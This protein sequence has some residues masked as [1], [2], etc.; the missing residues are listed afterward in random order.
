MNTQPA[1]MNWRKLLGCVVAGLALAGAAHAQV[2]SSVPPAAAG[3][4]VVT[5]AVRTPPAPPA[6]P[7]PPAPQPPAVPSPDTFI[8][9]TTGT[10]T[11]TTV[12]VVMEDGTVVGVP[13]TSAPTN[14]PALPAG[15]TP[16]PGE[17]VVPS[18]EPSGDPAAPPPTTA[19]AADTD[20]TNAPPAVLVP[21]PGRLTAPPAT[22]GGVVMPPSR[23]PGVPAAATTNGVPAPA[24]T[25]QWA[26][27]G[28]TLMSTN[29]LISL[30]FQDAPVD[31]ILDF[32]A[33]MTGRTL[34]RAPD[35]AKAA[36][37]TLRGQTRL[38]AEE[39]R[40]AIETVLAI[41]NVALVPMGEKFLK[42]VLS[43]AAAQEAVPI[44]R[45]PKRADLKPTDQLITQIIEV[46]HITLEEA[47]PIVQVLLHAAYGRVYP[48][49][50]ANSLM[51]TDTQTSIARVL[52]V[53]EFVDRPIEANTDMRV[54][55][56]RYA[57]AAQIAARINEL[58]Q[59]SQTA[60]SRTPQQPGQPVPVQTPQGVILRPPSSGAAALSSLSLADRG[61]ITG[62]LKVLFD[63]R[64]NL[65]LVIGDPANFT[66]LDKVVALLDR[67]VEP[68]IQFSVYPLEFANAEDTAGLLNEMVGTGVRRTSTGGTAGGTTTRRTSTSSSM[69]EADRRQQALRDFITARRA[70]ETAAGQ[71]ASATGTNPEDGGIGRI[72]PETRILADQR[73]NAIIFMGYKNDLETLRQV[74]K[75]L[76]VMLAQVIIEAVILEVK[77]NNSTSYGL[78]WLQ[79]SLTF[80]EN[81]EAGPNGGINTGRPVMSFGGG[82]IGGSAATF[83][84]AA[85]LARNVPLT[86]GSLTYYAT[87]QN[88]NLDAIVRMAASSGDARILST[89]VILTTDNTEA[90]IIAGEERPI[91]T[92][93]STTDGGTQTSQYQYRNIGIE[94]TVTPRIN[95]Q[96]FVVM[97]VTQTADNVGDTIT[98]DGNEVPIITKR[99]LSA[100]IAVANR[101]TVIL[102]GLVSQADRK[103]RVG[104]PFLSDIPI[105]GRLFRTD[106]NDRDRSELLVLLTPYVITTPEEARA[107]T[108][109][110]HAASGAAGVRWYKSGWSDGD[111]SHLLRQRDELRLRTGRTDEDGP[112]PDPAATATNL[113]PAVMKQSVDIPIPDRSPA[114]TRP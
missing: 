21:T 68:A 47:Q 112:A 32:Y 11:I 30:A 50:R 52:E 42:V 110:L 5:N 29:Q 34:I 77:L 18:S 53:L 49:Q 103:S 25:N 56:I 80:Y 96:R 63:E 8:P 35:I 6:P 113:P 85:A 22:P 62:P 114:G 36:P 41:N 51:V 58:I 73:S 33:Q 98:I 75:Q 48:L 100:S 81:S 83:Q 99:E 93:T 106:N 46:K 92:A 4:D 107:E 67:E 95:P 20:L 9:P 71:P 87:L 76:D 55:E 17:P 39:A 44:G 101:S 23:L 72:S 28:S 65:V 31:Q 82:L 38:T 69:S 94:L 10:M 57:Q 74:T 60:R 84:D 70:E 111:L 3:T 45:D 79:R 90:K 24:P 40:H 43:P 15:E 108:E 1:P 59:E 97:E 27:A 14:P 109:R 12:P 102:G 16:A 61:L 54:Y 2:T 105:L 19:P 37:I 66:F 26:A 13:P 88:L 78:D 91:V 89:P 64:T 7:M 104:I 86:G